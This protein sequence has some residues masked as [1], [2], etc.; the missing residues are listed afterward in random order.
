MDA[1]DDHTLLR[2]V[3]VITALSLV[4]NALV[5]KEMCTQPS[6]T[7]CGR[8][9]PPVNGTTPPANA[10]FPGYFEC[11]DLG[12]SGIMPKTDQALWKCFDKFEEFME[13]TVCAERLESCKAYCRTL[14]SPTMW[15]DNPKLG[16]IQV[17][18]PLYT[19]CVDWCELNKNTY[20][21]HPCS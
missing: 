8:T 4:S 20:P 13:K 5:L 2:L 19:K 14:Q 6:P 1:M 7:G 17:E 10:Y 16:R 12:Y 3:L 15:I 9:A 18:N 21:A 11:A